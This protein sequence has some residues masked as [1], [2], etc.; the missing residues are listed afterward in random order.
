MDIALGAII[1]KDKILLLKRNQYPYKDYWN[2]PGGKIEFG[3]FPEEA[4]VREAKEETGLDCGSEGLKGVASEIVYE[5]NIQKAH[6]MIY[7]SKLKP[8]HTNTV[9]GHEGKL[10]WFEVNDLEKIKITPSDLLMLKEFVFKKGNKPF[11]KIKM[12]EKDGVYSVEEFA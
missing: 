7:V 9:E 2:M 12:I 11:Y 4:A 6:F 8:V 5:D 1:N 10:R 3:E